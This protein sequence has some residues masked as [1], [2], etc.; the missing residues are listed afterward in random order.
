MCPM[1]DPTEVIG[2]GGTQGKQAQPEK[3]A[4][5]PPCHLSE[6]SMGKPSASG[7]GRSWA[8]AEHLGSVT[9][10]LGRL[11]VFQAAALPGVCE[12]QP[13]HARRHFVNWD[14]L[15]CV[16]C[17]VPETEPGPGFRGPWRAFPGHVHSSC[18][19]ALLRSQGSC[20]TGGVRPRTGAASQWHLVP[21]T[22]A[23]GPPGR[24]CPLLGMA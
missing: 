6:L 20:W 24:C 9:R 17:H 14:L 2:I 11:H 21:S 19:S 16:G 3:R 12:A 5:G 1:A 15:Q 22:G 4:R 18:G 7:G 8:G 10:S 23:S 13:R